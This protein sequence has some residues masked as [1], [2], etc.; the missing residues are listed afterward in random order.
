LRLGQRLNL[1]GNYTWSHCIGLP[2]NALTGFGATYPHGPYQNTGPTN[3]SLDMGDCTSNAGFTALDVRH[4]ANVTLVATTPK[5]SGSLLR[6]LASTWTF[7]TI[8]QARS[9][10]P[11]IGNVGGD[12]AYNG[13]AYTGGSALP[14]PQRP[15]QLLADVASPTRGQGCLPSPCVSWFNA[16]A[17]AMPAPGTYGN[18]GVGGLRGPGFWDWSQTVSRRFQVAE[19]QQVEFRAEAF[20][21][22]N[23]VRLGNPIVNLSGG[24]FGKITT[25]NGGPRIMQ[26][27]LKYVF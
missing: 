1:D 12:Q 24:Q 23:S 6:S 5:Y 19:G 15:N 22:T 20:N 9:G 4:L 26:F 17:V 21:V 7:S 8:F 25:S 3:R 16:N 13:M 10:Q 14:I 11:F 18:M 2:V 27:A